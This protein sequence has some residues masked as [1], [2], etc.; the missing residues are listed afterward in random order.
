MD[1]EKIDDEKLA[2]KFKILEKAVHE[3]KE[4]I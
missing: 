2:E 1:E 3:G 4:G